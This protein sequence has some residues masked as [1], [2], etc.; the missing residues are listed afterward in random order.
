MQLLG[1]GNPLHEA[2]QTTLLELPSLAALPN[3][4]LGNIRPFLSV[5]LHNSLSK[6]LF[7]PDWTIGILS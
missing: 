6:L 3:T 5:I 7:Y 1:H 2:S 4:T